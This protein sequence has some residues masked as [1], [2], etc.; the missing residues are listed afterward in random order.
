VIDDTA[1]FE[2]HR[3]ALVALAYRMLGGD[4]ARAEDVVQEAWL[5]WQGR[6][7]EVDV[8][9]AFL[10][11]I[12]THLCLN[13]LDSARARREESRGDRLPEPVDLG[14]LGMDRVEMLDQISMAFLVVLQR[15]TP[16]ERAVLLLHDVFDMSHSDIA[17]LLK[18]TEAACR[19]LLSRGRDNVAAER[20][21]LQAS[22]DEHRQ[23]LLA[24]VRAARGGELDPM[25]ALLAD[26]ATLIVDAGTEGRRVGRIRN[27][28]RPVVGAKRIA[29]FLAA[30]AREPS[31]RT[32]VHERILNGQPAIVFVREDGRPS[33]A[34]MVSVADGCIRHVFVQADLERL[35]HL[36]PMH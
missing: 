30:V 6:A 7:V 13:E 16:A 33:A 28:G 25:L 3:R 18:K 9:K 21:V 22:A 29:A 11:K 24:F 34:L 26:D 32:C 1:I 27:L 4:M 17:A 23:L 12:V 14:E 10:L 2:S 35:R 31:P 5:R 19:Q 15:L 36:G 8:P 20:R